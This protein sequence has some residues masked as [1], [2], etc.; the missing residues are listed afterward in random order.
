MRTSSLASQLEPTKL[1]GHLGGIGGM[2]MM[3]C[4]LHQITFL[5]YFS[6]I[7]KGFFA[8]PSKVCL[9]KCLVH[10]LYRPLISHH[11]ENKTCTKLVLQTNLPRIG[12]VYI[13]RTGM[14][15]TFTWA[16]PNESILVL[17]I[18]RSGSYAINDFAKDFIKMKLCYEEDQ[19]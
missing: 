8:S 19:S 11:F 3:Q 7:D 5:V 14:N 16:M 17:P 13:F 18:T 4:R 6:H 9:I 15:S 1:G 10:S 12:I 2:L